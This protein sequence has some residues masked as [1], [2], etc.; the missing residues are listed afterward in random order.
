MCNWVRAH[1]RIYCCCC[2]CCELISR[3]SNVPVISPESTISPSTEPPGL[4]VKI[5]STPGVRWYSYRAPVMW[6]GSRKPIRRTALMSST[7]ITISVLVCIQNTHVYLLLIIMKVEHARYQLINEMDFYPQHRF[8]HVHIR[9][10]TY[11]SA[12]AWI[13]V[14][15]QTLLRT[16][17][18]RS[19][20]RH[21]S[22]G[23]RWSALCPRSVAVA[24]EETGV[25]DA[26]A[27]SRVWL[28]DYLALHA[29]GVVHA[30][31]K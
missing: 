2:L 23:R 18:A 30:G 6:N 15:L 1:H 21:P 14:R 19:F 26:W 8:I 9:I 5:C 22:R 16:C 24:E 10:A 20:C 12:Q 3:V 7:K 11:P 25:G 27:H 4:R 28:G 13:K 29:L 31:M 17:W